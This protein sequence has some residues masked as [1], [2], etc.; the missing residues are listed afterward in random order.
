MGYGVRSLRVGHSRI[1]GPELYWMDAWDEWYVLQFQS[2][3]IQGE[4]VVALVNTSPPEDLEAVHQLFPHLEWA[5]PEGSPGRLS[6]EPAEH[7]GPALAGVGLHP[8]D[9]THVFLTPLELYTTGTVPLFRNAAICITKR[10]WIH[11]HTY[12]SHPHDQRFRSISKETLVHLVTDAW[13][14]VR[15]LEDEDEVAPGLRT[16]WS[17]AHHRASM[18]V[19]VDSSDGTVCISDSYFYYENVE[20]GRLLGLNE[21][22][23]EVLD[24]NA[25][26]LRTAKHIIPIH[27]PKV[28][29]RYPGGLVAAP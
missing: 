25:R 27:D 10:G 6:R 1:R 15:L 24:T 12:H 8:D 3:L 19:E 18:V 2:V 17:G 16:W 11:H 21:N 29:E 4:G 13:D 22:M 7:M 28:F 20:Q 26:V 23:Y 14:R 5:L 9:I